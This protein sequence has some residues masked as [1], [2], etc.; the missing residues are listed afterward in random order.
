MSN[1][2]Q[3]LERGLAVLDLLNQRAGAMGVREVARQLALSPTIVQRL[4]RTLADAG[5]VAQDPET[6][7]Y[8]L[9]YRAVVLGAS[10]IEED[11]LVAAAMPPLRRLA[12]EADLNAFLGVRSGRSLVY[13]L[14]LQSRGPIAIKSTPGSTA[15][16][17]AT[18]MGKALL[19]AMTDEEVADLLG[20]GPLPALTGRTV[21]APDA[22]LEDLALARRRGYAL[23][24]EENLVGV[25]SA[26]ACVRNAAGHAVASVSVAYAPKLQPGHAPAD[27]VRLVVDAA[28]AVSRALGCPER[29]LPVLSPS[30][31]HGT[32]AA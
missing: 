10:L 18:A 20:P 24:D 14:A 15:A 6:Q 2:S 3:S 17:H 25:M 9:G 5:Y 26:G 29:S 30:E 4:L 19:A 1:T 16:F 32:D 21:T 23:S 11:S 8:R 31:V 27:V 12:D 28:A 22:L 13:V 7:K